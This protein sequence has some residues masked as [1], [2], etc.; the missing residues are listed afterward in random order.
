MN[1]KYL[2]TVAEK[3]QIEINKTDINCY[4][5]E[6]FLN[7]PYHGQILFSLTK[8]NKKYKS[9]QNIF[10]NENIELLI[11]FIIENDKLLVKF[12]TENILLNMK[13]K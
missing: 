6:I 7:S 1:A 2:K 8:N 13:Y 12:I 3:V 4:D 11:K 9:L 10:D 5:T